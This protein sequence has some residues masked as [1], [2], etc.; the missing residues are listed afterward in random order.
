M[1]GIYDLRPVLR[2]SVNETIGLDLAAATRNGPWARVTRIGQRLVIAVGAEESPAWQAQSVAFSA[3][4]R[5]AG[6]DAALLVVPKAHHFSISPTREGVATHT[7][8]LTLIH[9]RGCPR[10]A[11]NGSWPGGERR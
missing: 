3:G 8:L 4:C 1:S 9:L 5:D 7:A 6:C 2:I 10:C 11:Q